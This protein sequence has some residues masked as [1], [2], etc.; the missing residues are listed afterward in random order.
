MEGYHCLSARLGRTSTCLPLYLFGAS[1]PGHT[2]PWHV[3]LCW[4]GLHHGRQPPAPELR[5]RGAHPLVGLNM[6][7]LVVLRAALVLRQA[8]VLRAVMP[9]VV[10]RAVMPL[11]VL[12]AAL[13]LRQA[14][15]LRAVMPLVVLRAVMPLV[16]VRAALLVQ[17]D[18]SGG[19]LG[20]TAGHTASPPRRRGTPMHPS[21]PS[22]RLGCAWSPTEARCTPWTASSCQGRCSLGP[23]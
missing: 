14:Q 6:L 21:R 20:T 18:A 16:E 13:V 9:L 1:L 2:A 15:V 7:L 4:R 23:S 11:V 19:Q 5:S 8:Q 3:S 12:R 22:P 10:L 17:A